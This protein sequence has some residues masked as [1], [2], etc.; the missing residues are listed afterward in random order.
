MEVKRTGGGRKGLRQPRTL[1]FAVV[2]LSVLALAGTW[3]WGQL[4]SAPGGSEA[5][6][7]PDRADAI[8]RRVEVAF[9]DAEKAWGRA[10]A[11]GSGDRYDPASLVFFSRAAATPCAGGVTVSGPFYCADTGTAAFDLAFLA[12]LA[13]RLQRQEELGLALVAARISAEHLQRELGMLD[14]AALRLIGAGRGQRAVVGEALELQAD[15]LTGAWAAAAERRLGR[16]PE[17]FWSQLVWSWR[18]V[19]EELATEDVRVPAEF[20]A[21]ARATR[22]ERDSAFRRG[23][24]AGGIAACPPPPEIV[25]RR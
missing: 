15:C 1:A 23:Y 11:D 21:F 3:A 8:M 24:A 25:A 2:A 17:G 22:D 13:R 14:A 7:A 20:N 4:H 6:V 19:V 16:V 5:A 12:T 10:A 9:A 18:N